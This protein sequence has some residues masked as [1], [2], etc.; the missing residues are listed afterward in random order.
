M[1]IA[2]YLFPRRISLSTNFTQ[3][4]TIHLI[5]ASASPEDT[6]FSFAH[7]TMPFEASTWVTAA[8]ALAAA[9]VAPPVYANKFNTFISFSGD[10]LI[11]S[12][13]QSQLAACSG[14]KPVCLKLNGFK[15]K[16]RSL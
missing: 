5:G 12:E 3:S 16:V 9:Q 13:N 6:A 11:S 4:S 8:P 14:N 15:L 1:I 2:S 10:F 7:V